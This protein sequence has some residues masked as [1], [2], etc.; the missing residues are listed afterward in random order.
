MTRRC[1]HAFRRLALGIRSKSCCMALLNTAHIMVGRSFF[2]DA[3]LRVFQAR[4][5]SPTLVEDDLKTIDRVL[6]P[7]SQTGA[8]ADSTLG[9]LL[10]RMAY[11]QLPSRFYSVLQICAPL[12]VEAWLRGWHRSA[13]ALLF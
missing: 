13:G 11:A 4:L 8:V 6:D 10:R 9:D 2:Y 7:E 3:L 12:A 1:E 5:S